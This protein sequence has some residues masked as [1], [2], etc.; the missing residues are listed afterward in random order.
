MVLTGIFAGATIE[1]TTVLKTIRDIDTEDETDLLSAISLISI[2]LY[3]LLFHI[4]TMYY[5][6]STAGRDTAISFLTEAWLLILIVL[7]IFGKKISKCCRKGFN[8][9]AESVGNARERQKAKA[10]AQLEK[11]LEEGA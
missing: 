4:F 5:G 8:K 6:K 9:I 7:S 11:E 10:K 1:L 3:V 2:I